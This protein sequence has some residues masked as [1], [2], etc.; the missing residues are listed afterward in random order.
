MQDGDD[1]VQARLRIVPDPHAESSEGSS[2]IHS[3]AVP[4]SLFTSNDHGSVDNRMLCPEPGREDTKASNP[5]DTIH[6]LR[7]YLKCRKVAPDVIQEVYGFLRPLLR[8]LV[9]SHKEGGGPF[10]DQPVPSVEAVE[11]PASMLHVDLR[12]SEWKVVVPGI[13]GSLPSVLPQSLASAPS[14]LQDRLSIA[15][16]APDMTRFFAEAQTE[17]DSD[18][19]PKGQSLHKD[20]QGTDAFPRKSGFPGRGGGQSGMGGGQPGGG[21][22]GMSSLYATGLSQVLG[23]LQGMDGFQGMNGF[24]EMDG[25]QGMDGFFEMDGHPIRES[26]SD[27]EGH[28]EMEH[29]RDVDGHDEAAG[30][31]GQSVEV[32]P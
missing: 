6:S 1:P 14:W 28:T 26:L 15:G 3:L 5:K 11:A 7:L 9:L 20:P 8:L 23:R 30:M 4:M 22:P 31:E 25:F 12:G 17:L 24:Q 13:P 19:K 32:W 18:G 27:M 2:D 21:Q 29:P 10:Q 16:L